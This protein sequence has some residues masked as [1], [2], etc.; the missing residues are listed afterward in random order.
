M[1]IGSLFS[2]IGGLELGLERAGL[3]PVLWQVEIDVFCRGVLA[4]HWPQARRFE[5]VRRV[6][7][8]TLPAVDLI[9]GGFPC[10]DVSSAGRG[11]GLDGARSG[12]W[13]E[14]H[15]IVWFAQPKWVVVENVASGKRRWLSRVRMDLALLG[16]DSLAVE[17]SAF[18]VGAPHRRARVFV[19]A[20]NTYGAALRNAE[21]RLSAR[22]PRG[23]RDE[24]EAEPRDAGRAGPSADADGQGQLQPS[25][26]G[27]AQWEWSL[28][29]G[30]ERWSVV[31][32]VRGVAH[33]VPR[34]LDRLRS[35]GNAVVPQC[36][37]AIGRLI[38][39]ILHTKE[40]LHG[41]A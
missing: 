4:T 30:G 14:F 2:G 33:G 16:Y 37:E 36:A 35:L 39:E 32:P 29:G 24:G 8:A 5:D 27:R 12:L 11:A 17:V 3:G 34:R 15:R 23:V 25:G 6:D 10:Q 28:D 22:R 19:L 21:Q 1:K 9:C 13:R 20:S 41:V 26:R 40:A 18:D 7:P 38:V 31:A